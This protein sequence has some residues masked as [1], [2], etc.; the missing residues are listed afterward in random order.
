MSKSGKRVKEVKEKKP[1][2]KRAWFWVL[3]GIFVIGIY[4]NI[5]DVSSNRSDKPTAASTT[6]TENTIAETPM[7]TPSTTYSDEDLSAMIQLV[8]DYPMQAEDYTG[9]YIRV[10]GYLRGVDSDG[11]Y[12]TIVED[13]DALVFTDNIQW[14]MEKNP[15]AQEFI[16]H[17]AKDTYITVEGRITDVGEVIYYLGDVD[18]V[19]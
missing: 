8:K 5:A 7:E 11:K 15:E 3:I 1:L 9:Q 16:K 12:F 17:T 2:T 14:N 6:P 13:K 4:G 19:Y 18:N 10:S